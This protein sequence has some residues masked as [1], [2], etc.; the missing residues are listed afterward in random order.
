MLCALILYVQYQQLNVDSEQQIFWATFSWYVYL[1]SEIL[2]AIYREEITEEIF[3]PYFVLMSDLAMN[4]GFTS[5]N[6]AHYQ[7]DLVGNIQGFFL[8]ECYNHSKKTN[9]VALLMRS[10]IGQ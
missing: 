9:F 2:P 5:N 6:P 3:F 1:L 10:R 4:L 7:L 8:Y